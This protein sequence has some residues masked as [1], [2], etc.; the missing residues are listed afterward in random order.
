MIRALLNQDIQ[1]L[2][3]RLALKAERVALSLGPKHQG[4]HQ[5]R[6]HSWRSPQWLWPDIFRE[7]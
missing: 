1:Q 6:G 3:R 5:R 4:T 7:A 2:S